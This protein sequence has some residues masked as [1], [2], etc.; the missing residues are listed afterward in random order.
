MLSNGERQED[1][2]TLQ[3]QTLINKRNWDMY[4]DKN[5]LE[6]IKN[7]HCVTYDELKEANNINVHMM[8]GLFMK[9]QKMHI[10]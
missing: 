3:N 8:E 7:V 6:L 2:N 10:A 9:M 4:K 5:Q 1:Y